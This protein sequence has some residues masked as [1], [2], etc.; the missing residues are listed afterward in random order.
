VSIEV[1]VASAEEAAAG[2][3]ELWL[4]GELL[5]STRMTNDH[6]IVWRFPRERLEESR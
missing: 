4:A 1:L 3:G 6:S 2:H 5:G